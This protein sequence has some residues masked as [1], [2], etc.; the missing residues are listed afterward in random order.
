MGTAANSV[1][2][3]AYA[4]SGLSISNFVIFWEDSVTDVADLDQGPNRD[5]TGAQVDRSDFGGSFGGGSGGGVRAA[6]EN[7]SIVRGFPNDTP[8]A[9]IGDCTTGE[10]DFRRPPLLPVDPTN[11][12]HLARADLR[13]SG[14]IYTTS[15]VRTSLRSDMV[16]EIELNRTPTRTVSNGNG[17]YQRL[18][19]FSVK[20]ADE[21]VFDFDAD[22]LLRSLSHLDA[23]AAN[24]SSRS[25]LQISIED[26]ADNVVFRYAPNETGVGN[27]GVTVLSEPFALNGNIAVKAPPPTQ[28][29]Q[30]TGTGQFRAVSPTLQPGIF[31]QLTIDQEVMVIANRVPE[32]NGFISLGL[33]GLAF[34]CRRRTTDQRP[35]SRRAIREQATRGKNGASYYS[36]T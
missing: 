4:Y 3:G 6:F 29:K 8:Q 28:D 14:N 9:C 30:H 36:R 2:A 17:T 11:N 19:L 12:L 18:I 23:P 15:N 27:I 34:A 20:F 33:A 16:A 24:L 10:N 25:M 7:T 32:P 35:N 22:I 1:H 13:S 21:F 5:G 26:T 31:Y